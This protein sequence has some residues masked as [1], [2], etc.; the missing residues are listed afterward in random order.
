MGEDGARCLTDRTNRCHSGVTVMGILLVRIGIS[1]D[2]E[3]SPVLPCGGVRL[4][5]ER[6][7]LLI[8]ILTDSD[9]NSSRRSIMPKMARVV[10]FA[11]KVTKQV[12]C[13]FR[14]LS[15]FCAH[16]LA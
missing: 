15:R 1:K 13:S 5:G 7:Y 14:R 4:P 3:T 12:L 8:A 2:V 11:K 10:H 9:F 6:I 16:F